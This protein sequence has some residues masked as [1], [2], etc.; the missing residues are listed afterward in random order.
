[1]F[2]LKGARATS[3]MAATTVVCLSISFTGSFSMCLLATLTTDVCRAGFSQSSTVSA[4]RDWPTLFID[5]LEWS[6]GMLAVANTMASHA[7]LAGILFAFD[8]HLVELVGLEEEGL[9]RV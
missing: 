1:M 8:Q 2:F 7:C 5:V 3:A 4:L 9:G 6:I